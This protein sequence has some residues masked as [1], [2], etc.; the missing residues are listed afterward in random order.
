MD[1]VQALILGIIQGLTEF[2][3][4][5]SSGHLVLVPWLLGWGHSS[6]VF[7]TTLHLGTLLALLLYFWGDVWDIL[8][9]WLA[10]W[11]HRDWSTAN[12]RLGWLIILASVP[13]GVAGLLFDDF[14]ESLFGAPAFV[15]MSLLATGVFLTLAERYGSQLRPVE[16]WA[17]GA[18]T[19]VGFAQAAAIMPG[20]S[21]SGATI[22]AG[23]AL[24][25]TRAAAAR[26]SF[27][28]SMPIIGAAGL[29]QL[30]VV[31]RDGGGAGASPLALLVGFVA[32]LVSG[33]LC[34]KFLLSYFRRGGLYVFA[35]YCWL[36]GLMTLAVWYFNGGQGLG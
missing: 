5:S 36:F 17:Y 19:V 29:S 1:V 13:A 35:V 16:K 34:V 33:Y 8:G 18:A 26:F 10:G 7:D 9:A 22:S 4:V 21:R 24:G 31:V 32:S 25:Y 2:I 23:M 20:L 27:L 3:P 15:G 30:Y 14:F 28:M 12:A 6:L 11:R